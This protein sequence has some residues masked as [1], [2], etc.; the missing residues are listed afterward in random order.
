[1]LNNHLE[2]L[3][4]KSGGMLDA[5]QSLER[6]EEKNLE[7]CI[8]DPAFS[9]NSRAVAYFPFNYLLKKT[10]CSVQENKQDYIFPFTPNHIC[11]VF[12]YA[13]IRATKTV[14]VL[15]H[16]IAAHFKDIKK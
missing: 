2:F 14:F 10:C 1:M 4:R 5:I 6:F 11:W 15:T 9:R 3:G 13:Q 12:A 16:S 7:K 8:L